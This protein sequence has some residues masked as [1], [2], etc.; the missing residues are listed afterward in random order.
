MTV[1]VTM[2]Q[3]RMGEDGNLWTV[4]GSP[5]TASLEF[6]NFL[7]GNRFATGTL[8]T[9]VQSYP[10]T[11]VVA[12]AAEI[13]AITGQPGVRYVERDG[14]QR[15]FRWVNGAMVVVGVGSGGSSGGSGGSDR[16]AVTP[17]ADPVNGGQRVL[18]ET[19]DGIPHTYGYD[20][21]GRLIRDEWASGGLSRAIEYSTV[22]DFGLASGNIFVNGGEI[23]VPSASMPALKT[24]LVTQGAAVAA[25]FFVPEL[26]AS[27]QWDHVDLRFKSVD[28][29]GVAI[30][31]AALVNFA[32]PGAAEQTGAS[33]T[34]PG[35]LRGKGGRLTV[36]VRWDTPNAAITKTTRVKF[37]G[38]D[39]RNTTTGATALY[40]QHEAV[41]DCVS[42]ADVARPTAGAVMGSTGDAV[43]TT[44]PT[45]TTYTAN[46][47]ITVA[48]TLTYTSD[49]GAI[50]ARLVHLRAMYV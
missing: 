38:T 39:V 40:V 20:A 25:R 46:S 9:A 41:I 34:W 16:T 11:Q 30:V 36:N 45:Q 23:R 7:I 42:D 22:P 5:Y 43:S 35:W 29:G 47:D 44:T 24:A 27:F 14:D 15:E 12:T 3:T 33:F 4:A 19:L 26:Q 32:S 37:N 48:V 13:A 10:M 49:P 8:P 2:L 28:T 31:T 6:A 50:T 17:E 1:S 21:Q 18:S